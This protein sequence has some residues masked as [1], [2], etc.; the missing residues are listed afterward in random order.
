VTTEKILP[1]EV[2]AEVGRT[3]A[4]EILERGGQSIL[5]SMRVPAP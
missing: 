4:E 1:L 2:A 5:E 3:A